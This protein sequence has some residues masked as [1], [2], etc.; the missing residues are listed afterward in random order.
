ML[1]SF[2]IFCLNVQVSIGGIQALDGLVSAIILDG[3]SYITS[4]NADYI[5][6][7]PFGDCHIQ[8]RADLHYGNDDPTQWAQP[9]NLYQPFRCYPLPKHVTQP[10]DRPVDTNN[11]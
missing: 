7:P 1:A 5:P 2:S 10:P 3:Q 9:Y 6:L 11:W 4:A 8:L